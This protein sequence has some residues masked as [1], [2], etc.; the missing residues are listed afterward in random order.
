MITIKR[1]INNNE[2]DN[3]PDFSN[4][5]F[6]DGCGKCCKLFGLG[7][8]PEEIN[9]KYN[10]GDGVCKYLDDNNLCTIYDHR[11]DFCNVR[12]SYKL[13]KDKLTP[14]EYIELQNEFCRRL[15]ELDENKKKG[16]EE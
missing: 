4:S 13:V 5:F 8:F 9:K 3:L 16:D 2:D 12:K 11:P 10:R 15:K 14:E 7:I 1:N 6:C